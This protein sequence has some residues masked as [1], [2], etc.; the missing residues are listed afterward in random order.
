M[1]GFTDEQ[2]RRYSRHIILPDVGGKGQRKLLDSK[3]LL[4]GAGG[5]GSPAALYLAAAGVGQLGIVDFDTVDLSN[6]QRQ[7]IHGMDDIGRYKTES[8]KLS[9]ANMNP[10]VN[11]VE[12]REPINSENAERIVSQY[13]VV[14]DGTDNFPSR[15]LMNDVTVWLKKPLVYGSIFQFDG[16]MTVFNSHEGGPCY[17]CLYPFPPPPGSVPSCQQAGVIG[18]LPGIVGSIQ[19]AEAIKLVLGIGESLSGRLLTFEALSM[20]FYELKIRR[21]PEC[22]VCGENPTIT[23]LIDYEEFCGVPAHNNGIQEEA[24]EKDEVLS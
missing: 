7:V 2:I 19:A 22:P 8:A 9:I 17:R 18:I 15:Y 5:L 11:V 6:L 13:D 24:G 20:Q 12:Y 21:N 1:L 16:Q 10:D 14:V 4:I 3:V 23:E